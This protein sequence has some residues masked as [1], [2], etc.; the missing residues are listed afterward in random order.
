[1][2][3]SGLGAGVSA[4][5]NG[6]NATERSTF[7]VRRSRKVTGSDGPQGRRWTIRPHALA[8]TKADRELIERRAGP[9]ERNGTYFIVARADSPLTPVARVWTTGG[10]GEMAC[11]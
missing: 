8:S 10:S 3:L 11:Y 4:E 1:M 7:C 6:G 2:P 5:R 9:A